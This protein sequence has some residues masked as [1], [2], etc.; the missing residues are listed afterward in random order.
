MEW[1]G[2]ELVHV[3]VLVYVSIAYLPSDLARQVSI[4]ASITTTTVIMIITGGTGCPHVLPVT[5]SAHL[6]HTHTLSLFSL[7]C[8]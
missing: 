4:Y 7:E 8:P 6:L 1:N 2:I 3:H 5:P